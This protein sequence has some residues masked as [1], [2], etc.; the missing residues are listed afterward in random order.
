MQKYFKAVSQVFTAYGHT[1]I[2][3][4]S[5]AST[6]GGEL[7]NN[8]G[9]LF[10]NRGVKYVLDYEMRNVKTPN[11]I[12]ELCFCDSQTEITI[13][14]NYSWDQLAYR[15]CNAIDSNIPIEP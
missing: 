5:F 9:S 13:Y 4:N 1:V 2:D 11:I 3:C 6:Q 10:T 15:F 8:F 7:F 12:F 14:N